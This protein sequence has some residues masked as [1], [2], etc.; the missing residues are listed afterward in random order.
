MN[1]NA[2]AAALRR[3]LE[4]HVSKDDPAA[5]VVDA[6]ARAAAGAMAV[7]ARRRRCRTGLR[8]RSTTA[9]RGRRVK[10]ASDA[11]RVK[12]SDVLLAELRATFDGSVVEITA[13]R[14]YAER[15]SR[16][17]ASPSCGA[18]GR[19]AFT[20]TGLGL[21]I[22]TLYNPAL[23]AQTALTAACPV[24]CAGIAHK[25]GRIRAASGD[26][27]PGRPELDAVKRPASRRQKR[28]SPHDHGQWNRCSGSS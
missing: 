5:N 19:F 28:Q 24:D 4:P 16:P 12:P 18:V 15:L 22:R 8:C 6:P 20:Q 27:Q 3:V 1:G 26:M 2:D 21:A 25:R 17:S 11:W 13:D 7:V 9:T 23:A 10:C 14:A